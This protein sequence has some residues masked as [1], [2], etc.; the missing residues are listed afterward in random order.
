MSNR[1]VNE[2]S[3]YLLL[4]SENP[5]QWHPWDEEALALAR[6]TDKPILLSIGYSACHWCHVM[7]EESF[8]DFDTAQ[9]MNKRYVNIKVDR[10]ER[11]DLDLI[12]Q[13]ALE[14]MGQQR[15]WPLTMFLTPDH[16]PFSGGTYFPPTARQ[17]APAFNDVLLANAEAYANNPAQ[18]SHDA[19]QR[20]EDLSIKAGGG[21]RGEISPEF[22]N[23]VANQI[24]EGMDIVYGGFGVDAKFPQTMLLELLWQAYLRTGH[25]PYREAVLRSAEHMCLGGISDHLG[26][27]FARYTVDDRWLI[28]HFE[29]ML[30]DNALIISLLIL[31]WR[32]TKNPLFAHS[33]ELTANWMVREMQTSQGGFF[34]SVAADSGGYAETDPGEGAFYVWSEAEIDGLLGNDSALFKKYYDVSSRGNWEDGKNI[35]NRTDHPYSKN[36]EVEQAL[37]PLRE[38]LFQARRN[39]PQ[40]QVDD[41][42]LA[43]WNGLAITALVE[44]G[45]TFDRQDWIDAACHAYRFVCDEMSSGDRLRHCY[46]QAKTTP[47]SLLDDY[48]NMAQ[49][50]ITLYQINGST[51]YL[52]QATRWAN[53]AEAHYWDEEAGGYFYTADDAEST[54]LRIKTA[55]ET[56]T[57]SGNSMRLSV[58]ARLYALTTDPV[59]RQR[60]E[61][62]VAAFAMKA[63]SSFVSMASLLNHSELLRNLMQFI[64]VNK[65]GDGQAQLIMRSIY[66]APTPARLVLKIAP[67]TQ[68]PAGHPAHAKSL[69]NGNTTVFVCSGNCCRPP[70]N[71][72][73]AMELLLDEFSLSS[74]QQ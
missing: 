51:T 69:H 10:E 40:P 65:P 1:L 39:R 22:L 29:K 47:V 48:A 3:P 11:P 71:G 25:T 74:Q 67:D 44:A 56:A 62:T 68:L 58:L 30:Y 43:D 9:I 26:G 49:A 8:E 61:Q 55:A 50:A 13:S 60:A 36:M 57:P 63:Q 37:D 12:Y 19:K 38:I 34:S 32:E 18:V 59:Y 53:I 28:P 17:G 15:G 7:A 35:L 14:N 27:G 66:E 42:I 64:V 72:L 73:N 52:A 4:H 24:L 41:K 46:R 45:V 20:L 6:D 31:V 2:T 33:I 5:V 21:N 16:E 54:I 70:V 23:H